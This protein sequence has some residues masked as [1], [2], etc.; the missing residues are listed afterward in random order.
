MRCRHCKRW[1]SAADGQP[2]PGGSSAPG[3]FFVLGAAGWL[4]A[5]ALYVSRASALAALIA[6]AFA[7]WMCLLTAIAYHDCR[8][9]AG[10]QRHGGERCAHCGR[11]N[12]MWPW[13][14]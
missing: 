13:S 9:P 2:A 6:A 3:V 11:P 1:Y 4:V 8:T 10:V 14:L 5:L 7:G 12:R